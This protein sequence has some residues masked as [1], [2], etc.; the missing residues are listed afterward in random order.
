MILA[1]STNPPRLTPRSKSIA[2]KYH[3]FR[4]HLSESSIVIQHIGTD[5]QRANILTKPLSRFQF[6][7]EREM[8]LGWPPRSVRGRVSRE[9]TQ[10]N[11]V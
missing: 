11:R 1:K 3:W 2:V 9:S 6:E 7:K 10:T 8:F 4:S 5:L